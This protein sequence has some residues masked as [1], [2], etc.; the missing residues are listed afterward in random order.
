MD[1]SKLPPNEYGLELIA[2]KAIKSKGL[3]RL[4]AEGPAAPVP[5]SRRRKT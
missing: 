3:R 1:P 4:L 5:K 2:V